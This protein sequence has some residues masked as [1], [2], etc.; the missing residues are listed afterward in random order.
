MSRD[1]INEIRDRSE[2]LHKTGLETNHFF[3]LAGTLAIN[4][5]REVRTLEVLELIVDL[6]IDELREKT[7]LYTPYK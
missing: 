4:G 6:L 7:P 5:G 3:A 1:L 2:F